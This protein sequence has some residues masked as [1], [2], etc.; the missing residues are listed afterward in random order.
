[1]LRRLSLSVASSIAALLLVAP[2]ASAS[3][4][5]G[6][7]CTATGSEAG[8]TLLATP[9]SEYPVSPLVK[10]SPGV[11]VGFVLRVGPGLGPIAQ[12]LGVFRPAG[13]DQYTKVAESAVEVFPEGFTQY[14]ARIPVQKGDVLGLHGPVATLYCGG[15]AS[16]S[17]AGAVAVGETKPFTTEGSIKPPVSAVIE[18]DWD[19]DGYGDQSQDGCPNSALFHT[20]CPLPA[21][22]IGKVSVKKRA[23]LIEAAN[24]TDASLEAAGEVRWKV[25]PVGLRVRVGLSSGAPRSVPGATPTLLRVPLPKAV[26]NRLDR[27]PPRRSLQA[28]L[29]V[30]AT[31]LVPYVGTQEIKV[32]LPGRKL[33]HSNP[34]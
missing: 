10:E 1:M 19:Q 16:A 20:A 13:G 24:N 15:G 27:L 5:A 6:W 11:I 12:Q 22:S 33:R 25:W 14:P 34:K 4:E 32:K 26:R 28:R 17:L 9:L 3:S 7:N 18:A 21:I 8:V 23:I 31:N 30:R 2:G 29:D